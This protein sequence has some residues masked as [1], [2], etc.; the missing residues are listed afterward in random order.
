MPRGPISPE[1]SCRDNET[2][3]HSAAVREALWRRKCR[4]DRWCAIYLEV[5]QP[6]KQSAF[7]T[8]SKHSSVVCVQSTGQRLTSIGVAS[9]RA[10]PVASDID[11][12]WETPYA[13]EVLCEMQSVQGE[14]CL[15]LQAAAVRNFVRPRN[16]Q[17]DTIGSAS[18]SRRTISLVPHSLGVPLSGLARRHSESSSGGHCDGCSWENYP[19]PQWKALCYRGQSTRS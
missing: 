19:H 10:S 6:V 13:E 17:H 12:H 7:S 3:C 5:L 15:G 14:G 8:G 1:P 11:C 16:A 2:L 18:K 9:Q 4:R